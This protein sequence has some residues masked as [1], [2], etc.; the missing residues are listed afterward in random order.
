[1]K[2][3][4]SET[5]RES[6]ERPAEE[7]IDPT[8]SA[9]EVVAL[10]EEVGDGHNVEAKRAKLKPVARKSFVPVQQNTSS[11]HTVEDKDDNEEIVTI[12][13]IAYPSAASQNNQGMFIL[14]KL[15]SGN[16][17]KME[18]IFF[19]MFKMLDVSYTGMLINPFPQI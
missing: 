13:P 5:D 17:I 12:T 6:S 3:G 7:E 18:R 11:R 4:S 19:L 16:A 14:K 8:V 10:M 2:R 15:T 1:M 9:A